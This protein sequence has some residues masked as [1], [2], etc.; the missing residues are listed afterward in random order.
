MEFIEIE[1]IQVSADKGVSS[2]NAF[3]DAII[4]AATEWKNVNLK[5]NDKTYRIG[6]NDLY[7]S[8]KEVGK[9]QPTPVMGFKEAIMK[10]ADVAHNA[11]SYVGAANYAE[12]ESE[13]HKRINDAKHELLS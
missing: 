6:P 10:M 2:G 4:L 8:V 7:A 11:V 12:R 9:E 13:A 3:R 1:F 5:F